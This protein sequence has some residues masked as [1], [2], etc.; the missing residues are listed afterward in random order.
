MGEGRKMYEVLVGKHE[1]KRPLGRPK[2]EWEDG[3]KI[4]LERSAGGWT[5]FAWFR[6]GTVG[7]LL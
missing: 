4:D 5:G 6:I 2:S 1:G 7:G 3:N